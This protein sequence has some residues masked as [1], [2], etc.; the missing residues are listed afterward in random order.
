M[1]Q[2]EKLESEIS[3]LE[4]K[5]EKLVISIEEQITKIIDTGNLVTKNFDFPNIYN[6]F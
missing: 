6:I 2:I 3:D 1:E 5:I 4:I